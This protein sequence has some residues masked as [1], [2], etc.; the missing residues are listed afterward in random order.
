MSRPRAAAVVATRDRPQLLA[1]AVRS[2]AAILAEGDELIVAEAGDSGAA[3]ALA[4]VEGPETRLVPVAGG[5]KSR[6]LNAAVATTA[7]PVLLFTDDDCRVPAG[8]REALCAALADDAVGIAFGPV[9][10]LTSAPGAPEVVP[11][12]PPG[13]APLATWTYAHG[14]SFAVRREAF[15]AVGGFDE[16]LGP[17]APAHG[18]EHDL[19]LRMREAGWRAVVA[20]APA[21][22]H[23]EWRDPAEEARNA[24]VYERGSGAFLG[25]A[26][27]RSP[28]RAWPLLKHRYGY[29]R[30]L[31]RDRRGADRAFA[32]RALAAFLGGLVY[33]V[34]LP[35][36][37]PERR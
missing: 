27:R 33:G 31:L 12:P 28:R 8:W 6:Q 37:P 17:G 5:G 18:E 35:P 13:E 25:A 34:R 19:L 29:A 32:R 22:A 30:Q 9:A 11:G 16:R 10:G 20:D 4:A 36:W 2:L 26:V 23:V 7:A 1:D 3:A 24:L 14:A 15:D 21:V